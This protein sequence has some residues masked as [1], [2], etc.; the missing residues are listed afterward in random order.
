LI[1][2][3]TELGLGTCW[4]GWF[5][6]RRVGELL[7]FSRHENPVALIPVGYP[8]DFRGRST[9]RKPLEEIYSAFGA[10]V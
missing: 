10:I 5:N 1:L 9:P 8:A 6:A 3:A 4:V 2:Q 7:G